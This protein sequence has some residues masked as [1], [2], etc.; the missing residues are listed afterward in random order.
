KEKEEKIPEGGTLTVALPNPIASLHPVKTA[1]QEE[2]EVIGSVFDTILRMDEQGHLVP[3]LCDN[4]EVLDEGRSFLFTLRR[5]IRMHDGEP[6][7]AVRMKSCIEQSVRLNPDHLPMAFAAIRGVSKFLEGAGD[8]VEGLVPVTGERL[9]IELQEPLPIYPALLTDPKSSIVYQKDSVLVGTGPFQLIDYNANS[10]LLKKNQNYWQQFGAHLDQ[11]HFRCGVSSA[12]IAAGI[13]SGDF[14]IGSN[15]L[16]DDL[17]KA[18]QDRQFRAGLAETPKKN[19]YFV[20]FNDQSPLSKVPQIRKALNGV[21]RVDDLVRA[22]LGRFAHPAHGLLPPG[23][24]GHDPGKRP[25][26]TILQESA[27]ELLSTAGVSRP[28]RLKAAVHPLFQDRYKSITEE[29]FKAWLEIGVEI[30]IETTTMKAYLEAAKRKE[31]L[32]LMIGRYNAD[33]DDPDNF[34]YF[35]FHSK[36]GLYNYYSSAEFDRM[37]EEARTE[38]DPLIREKLYRRIENDLLDSDYLLPLFHDIDYRVAGTRVRGLTLYA[39]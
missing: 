23:I 15:L 32:D 30:S 14:D 35:L 17:E 4:W 39:S 26:Q 33:Y 36:S 6:L 11:V 13:R 29:L 27:V 3:Y 38:N 1:I 19:I 20:L 8:S 16:P 22:T 25:R 12:Q 18:L 24:L 9:K 2:T 28:I 37:M 10:A 7:T 21:V 5:A 31:G 34:T